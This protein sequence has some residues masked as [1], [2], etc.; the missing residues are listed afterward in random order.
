MHSTNFLDLVPQ[1]KQSD[2]D[3][4]FVFEYLSLKRTKYDY[5]TIK[6]PTSPL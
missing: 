2:P 5:F 6:L 1:Q 4:P 3:V